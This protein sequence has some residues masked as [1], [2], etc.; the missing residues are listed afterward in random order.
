MAKASENHESLGDYLASFGA[1]LGTVFFHITGVLLL[2][3]L[4]LWPFMRG[5]VG[6]F[7][8]TLEQPEFLSATT[9]LLA[10]HLLFAAV[11]WGAIYGVWAMWSGRSDTPRAVT[12]SRG[13]VMTETLIV[14]PVL[15]FVLSG[16]AQTAINS[17]AGMLMNLAA[18]EAARAAWIWQPEQARFDGNHFGPDNEVDE[19]YVED[20]ARIQAAAVMTPVAHSYGTEPAGID[21]NITE[22][23]EQMRGA[24]V[25]G[26]LDRPMDAGSYGLDQGNEVGELG[27]AFFAG[28]GETGFTWRMALDGAR[29]PVRSVWKFS[30]AY[31]STEIEEIAVQDPNVVPDG[32]FPEIATTVIYNH[33]QAM[34]MLGWF[35]GEEHD[36]A[37][38]VPP[39][40][41]RS[42]RYVT[43]ERT[44][45]YIQQPDSHP[46]PF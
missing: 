26:Q 33:F 6:G 44:F 3:A 4:T 24:L 31:I 5:R 23:F 15:L 39:P 17:A 30:G 34:P 42:G 22:E 46:G 43:F 9:P 32:E 38:G 45:T 14:L 36:F 7:V 25:A 27:L 10:G 19:D 13:T 1:I 8:Q 37:D 35:W 21:S 12:T 16:M 40:G 29:Y 20:M 41:G 11:L 18:Y 28:E 2:F